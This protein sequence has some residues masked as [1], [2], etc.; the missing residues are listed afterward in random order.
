MSV[1]ERDAADAV[2]AAADYG[3]DAEFLTPKQAYAEVQRQY[4]RLG[5]L[6]KERKEAAEEYDS[7]EQLARRRGVRV[8]LIGECVLSAPIDPQLLDRFLAWAEKEDYRWL[9]LPNTLEE[10]AIPV[11]S[12][13]ELREKLVG[14][15]FLRHPLDRNFLQPLT[16]WAKQLDQDSNTHYASL[17][18]PAALEE[19]GIKLKPRK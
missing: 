13:Q 8:R 12:S 1:E 16:D 9:F 2:P 6:L 10:D 17:F 4:E 14:R 15:F 19:A 3:V 5:V 18:Q 11:A 7:P